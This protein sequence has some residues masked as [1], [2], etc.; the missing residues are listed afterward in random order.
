MRLKHGQF[1]LKTDLTDLTDSHK[2]SLEEAVLQIS[3]CLE[4]NEA[5]QSNIEK[6]LHKFRNDLSECKESLMQ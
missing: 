3:S 1:A 2:R 6:Q 4:A 5:M